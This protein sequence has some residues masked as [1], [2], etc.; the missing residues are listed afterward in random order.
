[1]VVVFDLNGTLLDNRAVKPVLR[2]IF[3]RKLGTEEFFTRVLQYSM[4]Y[5]LAGEYRP[6]GE[7]ALAVAGMEAEARK[8]KITEAGKHRLR[9]S[10][11]SL[12][13]F[14]EVRK[15]LRKLQKAGF[16][17]AV[18]TN[19]AAEDAQEQTTAAKLSD[20]FERIL[21]IAEVSRFKP[22][23]QTYELA[24]NSLQVGPREILMVAA[25]PW[26][27]MGAAAAGCQTAFI[28]RPG[29]ALLPGA[30]RPTYEANDV[31]ELTAKLIPAHMHRTS[32]I[33]GTLAGVG[34]VSAI[35]AAAASGRFSTRS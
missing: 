13:P 32:R 5:T 23:R 1:M 22:A 7:I 33:L 16:R 30:L 9:A 34:A 28:R 6:F 3:G 29:K 19:S 4:A 15:S 35:A 21:S 20:Y 2:S 10:L 24:A 8:I 17:L 31:A 26:D 14:C 18:L 12:P 27:L 11:R 25:H